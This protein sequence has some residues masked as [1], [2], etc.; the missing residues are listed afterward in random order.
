MILGSARTGSNFLL[1]LLSSHPSIKT[2]GELFNLDSLPRDDL[3]A[4][5]E[6]PVAYLQRRVYMPHGPGISAV[7]FK[8]FYDHLTK[9]YFDKPV[10]V[11]DTSQQLQDRFDRFSAFVE[12]NY[13]RDSLTSRFRAPGIFSL[14]MCPWR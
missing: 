7:G 11:A 6:D 8:M 10:R 5:L 12:S 14:K 2:Y 9:D 4:A 3:S 1:S 13:D